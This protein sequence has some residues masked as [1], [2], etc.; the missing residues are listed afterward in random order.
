MRL[1]TL[2]TILLLP[3]ALKAV[4]NISWLET[5]HNFGTI[6]EKDGKVSHNFIFVNT[7]DEDVVIKDVRSTCGCTATKG[8]TRP[9][10]PG[11]TASITATFN[12][13][14]RP[15]EFEMFF[16]VL[17]NS[18]PRRTSLSITGLVIPEESTVSNQYPVTVGSM[19]LDTSIIPFGKLTRGDTRIATIEA[20]ND[21]NDPVKFYAE[22]VPASISLTPDKG[23]IPPK[24]RYTIKVKI[25]TDK[26]RKYGFN[27]CQFIMLA[28]P[29]EPNSSA[30][31]GITTIEATAIVY[32]D[33]E[34]WSKREKANAPV[35]KID[36]DRVIFDDIDGTCHSAV[37]EKFS[38][39]N[40][41]K[42]TLKIYDINPTDNFITVKQDKSNIKPNETLVVEISMIPHKIPENIIN[43]NII[44]YSNDPEQPKTMLRVVGMK[45]QK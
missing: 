2:L 43:S 13:A 5:S 7:G 21:S 8:P 12:P 38:I 25:N 10:A 1:A 30:V 27:D 26:T 17:T 29:E 45:K 14:G 23:I 16:T 28:E 34:K 20:F 18:R 42:S 44:I 11:D 36:S 31:A 24:S 40:Y 15:G 9:I 4:G 33:F 35:I 32:E 3:L 22:D 37:V 39:T 19:R 6:A 41:G